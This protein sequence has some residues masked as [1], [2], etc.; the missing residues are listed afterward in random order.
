MD[1]KQTKKLRDAVGAAGARVAR[2][3]L[4]LDLARKALE[5]A[6]QAVMA[7][8]EEAQAKKWQVR[9][10]ASTA[11]SQRIQVIKTIRAVV[12][13]LPLKDAVEIE[14]AAS[15]V[16]DPAGRD[17]VGGP[18]PYEVALRMH[19]A[20]EAAGAQAELVPA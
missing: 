3:E 4:N 10:V 5:A 13:G 12:P 2:A 9:L 18:V 19:K 17:L 8:E 1:A 6:R 11:G 7:A 16:R 14:K 20:L 15:P